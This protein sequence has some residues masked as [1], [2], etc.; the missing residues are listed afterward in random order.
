VKYAVRGIIEKPNELV[1]HSYPHRI[2]ST[3]GVFH[4]LST[5]LSTDLFAPTSGQK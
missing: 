5:R 4:I 3:N 2:H 1:I